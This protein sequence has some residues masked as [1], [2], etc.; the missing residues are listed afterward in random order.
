MA[1]YHNFSMSNNAVDA[2][3]NGEMPLSKWSKKAI[4]AAVAD[5]APDALPLLSS[6]PLAVLRAHVLRRSSWHHTSSHY[7][8][9][10]FFALDDFVL[11]DLTPETVESWI[12][13]QK[14]A[15]AA[16][17]AAAPS[18]RPGSIAY[19]EWAGSIRRPRAIHRRLDGVFIE[20]KG[21]FFLV[22]D[23]SGALIL[24]KKVDSTGTEVTFSEK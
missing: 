7:N 22:F 4:L 18:R 20:Q 2:Y 8:K 23:A 17:P 11:E 9:T 15:A 10:D 5:A 24:R 16:A 3:E 12:R 6:C 14:D 21:A 13:D 1:G 19:I